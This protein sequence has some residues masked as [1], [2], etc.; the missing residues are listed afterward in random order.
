MRALIYIASFLCVMLL[1]FWAYRENYATQEMLRG[2]SRLNAQIADLRSSLAMQRAEWAYL[3]RPER[4][5]ELV[6]I[7]FD[8]LRLLP[9]TADQFGLPEQVTYP[10][11]PLFGA[12]I[13]PNAAQ[14]EL[15]P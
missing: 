15:I 13:D 11:Q 14:D 8:K 6:N 2:V 9:M 1:A 7:N 10:P 5:E 4:L 12:T 3:N